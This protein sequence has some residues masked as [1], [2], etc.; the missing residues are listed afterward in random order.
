MTLGQIICFSHHVTEGDITL[1]SLSLRLFSSVWDHLVQSLVISN[2]TLLVFA[3]KKTK[4]AAL[5]APGFSKITDFPLNGKFFM[6]QH[7]G[8]VVLVEVP[9]VLGQR[10]LQLLIFGFA[11]SSS[12]VGMF[13]GSGGAVCGCKGGFV[14]LNQLR[15]APWPSRDVLLCFWRKLLL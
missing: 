14:K 3:L 6:A 12:S 11:Q 15:V 7:L 2:V 13:W 1:I 9:Q 10:Q 4:G 8:W 5:S